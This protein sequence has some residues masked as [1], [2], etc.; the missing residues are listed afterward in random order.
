MTQ[1]R[2]QKGKAGEKAAEEF[3]VNQGYRI[4]ER[5]YRNRLGEIDIIAKEGKT[6]CFVEVKM[7]S[8]NR[9]GSGFEA[10]SLRKQRKISQVALSYLKLNHFLDSL[11]RFDVVAIEKRPQSELKIEI[12]KDAF[13]LSS[14][15]A[16]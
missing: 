16:Y 3:L 7:R 14:P 12:L 9:Q 10:I 5:N 8:G 6:I 4:L 15:Y 2:I 1:E 11:A 13:E